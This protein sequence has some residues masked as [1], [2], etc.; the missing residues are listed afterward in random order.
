VR[1]EWQFAG[2]TGTGDARAVISMWNFVE[3]HGDAAFDAILILLESDTH[4]VV[5]T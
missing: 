2:W 1:G 4:P 3:F 5:G